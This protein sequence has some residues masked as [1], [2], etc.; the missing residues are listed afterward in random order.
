MP[1]LSGWEF[2]QS[3]STFPHSIKKQFDIYMLS[4][5]IDPADI[6]RAKLNP[7][8]IDFIEKPMNREVLEQ[9]FGRR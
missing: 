4:S 8:V 5:S 2:L 9:L 1:T 3:F 6:E 7:L